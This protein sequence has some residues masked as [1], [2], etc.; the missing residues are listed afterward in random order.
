MNR[1]PAEQEKVDFYVAKA[2]TSLQGVL[3]RSYAKTGGRANAIR[4]KCY[5]CS[6][7]QREEVAECKVTT[8]PLHPWRPFQKGT[9]V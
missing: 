2:P 4:A 1:T 5:D 3:R 6:N 7:W 9:D 8:C